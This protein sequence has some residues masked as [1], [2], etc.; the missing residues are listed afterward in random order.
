M[1]LLNYLVRW[2]RLYDLEKVE[3]GLREINMHT[4]NYLYEK[5]RRKIQ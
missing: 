5:E 2:K 1:N 3:W 4:W